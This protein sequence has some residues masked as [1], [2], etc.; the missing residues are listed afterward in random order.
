ML[1]AMSLFSMTVRHA[2]LCRKPF[3]NFEK[4]E[5]KYRRNRSEK[6][7]ANAGRFESA[8]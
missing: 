7:N 4:N 6:Q 1:D 5:G 8:E 3:L 2:A